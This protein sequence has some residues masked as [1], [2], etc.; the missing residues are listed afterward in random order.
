MLGYEQLMPYLRVNKLGERFTPEYEPYGH[1]ALA[2]QAQPG[3]YDFY[4][5]DSAIGEKID[6]IWTPS[7]SCYGP[8][9]VWTAA[10]MSE[11]ALK[12]DTLEELAKLMG[13]PRPSSSPP[14]SA[15]TRWPPP[16]RTRTSTSLAR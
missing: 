8:K 3:T 16:A 2:I 13:C 7:S 9:E 15:G 12:A 4:V 11:K 5:V 1:L 14:S 6:K 10:A